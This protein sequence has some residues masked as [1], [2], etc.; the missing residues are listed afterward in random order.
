MFQSLNE[1]P[2]LMNNSKIS[3][4]QIFKPVSRHSLDHNKKYQSGF[5]AAG[6]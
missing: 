4:M 1:T 2:E 3:C 5:C 6:T